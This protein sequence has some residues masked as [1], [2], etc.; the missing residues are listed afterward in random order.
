MSQRDDEPVLSENAVT[1]LEN[2]YL[3]RDEQG[4]IIETP[5]QLFS[6][7]ARLVASIE[8][9][10]G[11]NETE[12]EQWHKK[13]YDLMASLK[14]LPNSPTLNERGQTFGDVERLFCPAD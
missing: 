9:N 14:F 1:V 6:R 12:V 10:Y 13:Y 7:V 4:K 11:S 2:R 5:G 8:A 3:I